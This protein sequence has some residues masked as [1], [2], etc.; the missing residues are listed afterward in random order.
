MCL[1]GGI[2]LGAAVAA[3]GSGTVYRGWI[4]SGGDDEML[5]AV[6]VSHAD[7]DR[8]AMRSMRE[9][10]AAA[11]LDVPGVVKLASAGRLDDG[12]SWVAMEWIDGVTLEESLREPY[13]VEGTLRIAAQ[14]ARALASAHAAGIVHRDLKPAN[15]MLRRENGRAVIVDFGIAKWAG[16]AATSASRCAGTPHYMAPEQALGE[17]CD[18]RADLYALGCVMV[19]M[20]TGKVP[21]DGTAVEVMLAHAGQPAPRVDVDGVPAAVADVVEQLMAKRPEDRPESAGVV[22]MRLE[23]LVRRTTVDPYQATVP[24]ETAGVSPIGG[25]GSSRST[26]TST[27]TRPSTITTTPTLTSMMPTSATRRGWLAGVLVAVAILGVSGFAMTN[28]ARMGT[29]TASPQPPLPPLVRPEPT[30]PGE[31]VAVVVDSGF[32][33]RATTIGE[34][35]AG[36]EMKLKL[37]I[38]DDNDEPID[39]T[40]VAATIRAPGGRTIALGVTGSNGVFELHQGTSAAGTHVISVFA[41]SGE[42]TFTVRVE[43]GSRPGV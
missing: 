16:E 30:A 2:R 31:P 14:L 24:V 3:G 33:M 41:P 37:E 35:I 39:A 22:A 11:R 9:A 34:P 21:F 28:A 10:Q 36:G 23:R 1:P 12:R 25:S 4:G 19:R 26:S 42:T 29:A 20:L 15:V 8:T 27:S 6:K 32:S 7:D 17:D 13:D 40:Q 5:V 18:E 38:W 43:V